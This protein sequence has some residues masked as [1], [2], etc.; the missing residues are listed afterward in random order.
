ME[1]GH[2]K[3][4]GTINE[5]EKLVINLDGEVYE[6]DL[7]FRFEADI[8]D[9]VYVGYTDNDLDEDGK[10]KIYVGCYKKNL[11]PD[12]IEPIETEEEYNMVNDVMDKIRS[13]L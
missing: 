7:L 6:Y 3:E 11:G 2:I 13:G 1:N 4:S 10:K 12:Y 8:S 5:D 9:K